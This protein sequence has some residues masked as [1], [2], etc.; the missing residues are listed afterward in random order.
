MVLAELPRTNQEVQM[1]V[2]VKLQVR[3]IRDGLLRANGGDLTGPNESSEA[4][5]HFD[6][7]QVR[8]MEL[9]P[10]AKE[11]RLDAR[12][13]RGLEEKLQHRRRV[14]DDHADSRSSRMILAAG[15]LSVTR[16]RP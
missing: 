12:A 15:V 1:G 2:A 9:I 3:E 13:K 7:H 16:R 5:S 6:V 14:D 8:R 10:V 11:T 4:P